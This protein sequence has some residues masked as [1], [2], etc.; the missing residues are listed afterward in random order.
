LS[1]GAALGLAHIGVL[2]VL[3][4][5]GIP[6]CALSG[7][8]MGSVVGG[9]Y[10]A[11]YTA[12]QLDSLARTID[13]ERQFD[14]RLPYSAMSLEEREAENRY[15]FTVPRHGLK[16]DLPSGMLQLQNIE[17]LLKSLLA[18]IEYNTDY[19]FDSLP[20]PFRAVAV[21]LESGEK[22]VFKNG[23]LSQAI[24]ASA[25]IPIVFTPASINHRLY[26]DGGV[27][28]D[29]PVEPIKELAP[30]FI[31][32]VDLGK[33]S[34]RINTPSLIDVIIRTSTIAT[35]KDRHEQ[36][37]LADIVIYPDLQDFVHSDFIKAPELIKRGEAAARQ[38]LPEIKR[39]LAGRTLANVRRA[40]CPRPL[41]F[42]RSITIT[43]LRTTK[44]GMI[45]REI[46]TR[47]KSILDFHELVADL[48][49]IYH[50]GLFRH[51]DY[52]LTFPS[53]DSVDIAF[54]CSERN[55]G[56]YSLGGWFDNTNGVQVGLEIAQAN[57]LGSGLKASIGGQILNPLHGWLGISGA[58]LFRFPF[59]YRLL[60]YYTETEH[61]YYENG[62]WAWDY[63]DKLWGG[64]FKAGFNIA[65]NGYVKFGIDARQ[66]TY[67][68]P[69]VNPPPDTGDRLITPVVELKYDSF[70]NLLFPADGTFLSARI[71]YA[72]R[73]LYSTHDF[74]KFE[75]GAKTGFKFV[76]PVYLE[77]NLR[78]GFALGI[79]PFIERFRT[80]NPAFTG[81]A[82]EEFISEQKLTAGIT[83]RALLF[84]LFGYKNYPV[85]LELAGNVATFLPYRNLPSWP[86]VRDSLAAGASV[87]LRTNTPVGPLIFKVGLNREKDRTVYISIGSYPSGL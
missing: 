14:D 62:D 34:M 67:Q 16:P 54:V 57:V 60:G 43:G 28:Q 24:R 63:L 13:W 83:G 81:Y 58:R 18:Q 1:G 2:K 11:G 36:Q 74:M 9:L 45:R 61:K 40:V 52:T 8:S 12:S 37:A 15:L 41:P 42:V 47:E 53:R 39:R 49:R 48:Q 70:K 32:A 72:S 22:I 6:I 87:G 80:G 26:V 20:I 59:N 31:I 77:P 21:D 73:K 78:A 84:H 19:N 79:L 51:V 25:A 76:G 65:S 66:V 86:A 50:T 55:F 3:E 64:E 30:D 23:S 75:F 7:N 33:R 69:G 56:T 38:A 27:V 85:Y 10:A 68:F 5:E 17:I 29:L 82:V 46:K 35:E 44:A 71:E 4:Q